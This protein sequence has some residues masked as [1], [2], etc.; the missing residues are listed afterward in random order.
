VVEIKIKEKRQAGTKKKCLPPPKGGQNM[1]PLG[2]GLGT[3]K[4]LNTVTS[5]IDNNE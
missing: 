3:Y 1:T 5:S 2:G 4:L